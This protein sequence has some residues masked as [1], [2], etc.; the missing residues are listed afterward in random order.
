MS[1]TLRS[2]VFN[3]S[4]GRPSA[5][6]EGAGALALYGCLENEANDGVAD[7]FVSDSECNKTRLISAKKHT[8]AKREQ[9]N[10]TLSSITLVN[11]T[12]VAAALHRITLKL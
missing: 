10:F 1:N 12:Q 9:R 7:W 3:L 4:E 8:R 11:C 2:E 5:R 6:D